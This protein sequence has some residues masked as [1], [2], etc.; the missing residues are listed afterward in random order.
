[1]PIYQY[2]DTKR[3]DGV[4]ATGGESANLYF[5]KHF[6]GTPSVLRSSRSS[7]AVLKGDETDEQ[8]RGL[9]DDIFRYSGMGCRSVSLLF[10]PQNVDMKR[11][12]TKIAPRT[13]HPKYATNYR[14]T[15]ASLIAQGIEF[16][17][18]TNF[19]VVESDTFPSAVSRINYIRYN[20]L[21]EVHRWLEEHRNELQCIVGSQIPFG[22]AQHPRLTD[23]AD[24]ID[25]IEWL[26]KLK[27]E[28]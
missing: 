15:R 12:A 25:V 9:S 18:G 5:R 6:E 28:N 4:I 26:N 11:L 19:V 16:V 24:G 14:Y 20:D 21:S 22:Q 8:L 27:V 23:Y 13:I 3:Y 1:M 17:E 10:V 7:V 2:D